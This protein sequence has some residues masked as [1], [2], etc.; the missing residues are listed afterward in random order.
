MAMK[1][2]RTLLKDAPAL[3]W[4]TRAIY[5]PKKDLFFCLF[6]DD[7]FVNCVQ[8]SAI[9]DEAPIHTW[10]HVKSDDDL[11]EVLSTY[12]HETLLPPWA[13]FQRIR[14][15]REIRA[16]GHLL[17]GCSK[18]MWESMMWRFQADDGTLSPAVYMPGFLSYY[19]FLMET[20]TWFGNRVPTILF[21]RQRDS[22]TSGP[23][24]AA[25]FQWN[26]TAPANTILGSQCILDRLKTLTTIM[27]P[28]PEQKFTPQTF[29]CFEITGE[30]VYVPAFGNLFVAIGTGCEE[31]PYK[32]EHHTRFLFTMAEYVL[33]M[34][35][36]PPYKCQFDGSA[37]ITSHVAPPREV[38][39]A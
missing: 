8:D 11:Q 38:T 39:K 30:T 12:R 27:Q 17:S 29:S 33:M 16:P 5:A 1:V 15:V 26:Q 10:K 28:N 34:T 36:C 20:S 18:S 32:M 21:D 3:W 22:S 4:D 19:N 2:I 35:G 9:G 23:P 37:W 14:K 7:I 6:D 31:G 13:D 25:T 24:S